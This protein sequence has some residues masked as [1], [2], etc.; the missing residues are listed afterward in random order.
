MTNLASSRYYVSTSRFRCCFSRHFFKSSRDLSTRMLGNKASTLNETNL[1]VFFTYSPSEGRMASNS[2]TSHFAIFSCAAKI[3]N[4]IGLIFPPGLC[5]LGNAYNRGTCGFVTLS[6][7]LNLG[8]G[9][10]TDKQARVSLFILGNVV[11]SMMDCK[12]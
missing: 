11:R 2:G 10:N 6:R 9:T 5:I 7:H 4:T 8:S 12:I 3:V 1:K